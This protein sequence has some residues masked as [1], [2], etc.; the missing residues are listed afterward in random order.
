M[1][2]IPFRCQHLWGN[3][4]V[5]VKR[6]PVYQAGKVIQNKLETNNIFAQR[7]LLEGRVAEASMVI[8]DNTG[9]W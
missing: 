9:T 5:A 6:I 1:L 7:S 4:I 3:Q 8:Q 2:D